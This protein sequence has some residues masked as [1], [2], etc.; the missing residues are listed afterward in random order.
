[1]RMIKLPEVINFCQPLPMP[2]ET[3][4]LEPLHSNNHSSSRLGS[5]K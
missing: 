1:M 2:L 4:L 3:F 5:S